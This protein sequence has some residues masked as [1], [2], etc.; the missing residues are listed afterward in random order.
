MKQQQTILAA[1]ITAAYPETTTR[2]VILTVRQFNQR[3]PAFSEAAI[4]NMVFKADDRQSTKGTIKGNGLIEAGAI[5]RL[6]RKVLIDEARFFEWI[7]A[8]QRGPQ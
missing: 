5:V 7:E 2:R 8:Q 1:A 6:G 3:N 4:R